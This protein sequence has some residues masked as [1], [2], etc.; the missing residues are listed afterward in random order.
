VLAPAELL[1]EMRDVRVSRWLALD[2]GPV[3]LEIRARRLGEHEI[4]VSLLHAEDT[5]VTSVAQATMVYGEAYPIAPV[6]ESFSLSDARPYRWPGDRLYEEAMFHGPAFRGVLTMDRVA[7]DG[8]LAT[9]VVLDRSGLVASGNDRDL[10]TDFVL[11]DLPGQVVG[12][13][14]AEYMKEGFLLLPFQVRSLR[15][16]GPMLPA[17]ER[18]TCVAR[19]RKI[20]EDRT[21]A[22]LDVVRSDGRVWARFEDW[23]DLRF[24]VPPAAI[25]LLL[26]PEKASLSQSWE[27]PI[28]VTRPEQY[29]ARRLGPDTLPPDWLNSYSGL[30]SRVL[31]ACVLSRRERAAWR[32]LRMP[33]R[34][35]E[36][37]LG[38]IVAKDAIREYVRR[39]FGL[40]LRPADIGLM[41]DADGRPVVDGPWMV[42]VPRAPLV[43]ISHVDGVAVAVA[44]D[45][46]G[47][48]GLGVDLE[49]V[50]RMEPRTAQF[51]FTARE[52]QW[53]DSVTA[54][55]RE[56]W[57]LRLWC[58][59]EACAKATGRG[60]V[61]GL[62]AFAVNGIDWQ[63]G[64]ISIRF[65]APNHPSTDLVALTAQDGEWIAATCATAAMESIRT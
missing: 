15:L 25:Q 54:P 35:N 10:V 44:G 28:G 62:H 63:R 60:L 49:R 9:M 29:V 16:Y 26:K 22:A 32:A 64:A 23:E 53:L 17:G 40:S 59:K 42:E 38:R 39:Q 6:A 14:A 47:L 24:D 57:S 46:D 52:L 48:I 34:S 5:G 1:I 45:D 8:A 21:R 19:I 33:A 4:A 36:W 13:W 65:E 55:E 3:H 50:G 7:E 56:A 20:G 61:S 43:S 12:F 18:L 58:A 51:A 2:R 27:V 37:L 11:L 31:A 30:W 41:P